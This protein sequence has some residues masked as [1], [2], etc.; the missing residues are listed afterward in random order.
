MSAP[1]I[2]FV[3]F[4]EAGS[5]LAAGLREE[6]L[7]GIVAYDIA[8]D[9]ARSRAEDCGVELVPS[10]ADLA[11]RCSI[12]I[13]VV[14]A[15]S[16]LEAA[17][18]TQPYLE[19]R[20]IYLDCN[21]VSPATKRE[22][23]CVTGAGPARFV[24]GAILAPVPKK[25]G[26]SVA[27]LTNGEAAAELAAQLNPLGF[28]MEPLCDPIGTAAAVKMCRSI[29]VKGL[30]A[31]LTECVLA[32]NHFGAEDRVFA[33]LQQ[34]YPGIEWKRL[35]DYMVNRLTVHGERRAHE[36]EEVASMLRAAGIDPVMAEATA[37]RQAWSAQ[38]GLG[39]YFGPEGPASYR[40]VLALLK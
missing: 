21:S 11:E 25:R 6:G 2:G 20:H 1:R 32:A 7:D 37:R 5:R 16:A 24:E 18:Q 17:R 29:V 35:A 38:L 9:R 39:A 31:L 23:A 4:G 28:S 8:P 30:E 33:S 34:S 3:G 10:N 14:T 22:I 27:M 40:D 19:A 36:M 13:S 26:Q 12:V 15:A